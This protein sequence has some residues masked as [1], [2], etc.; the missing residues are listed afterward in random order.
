MKMEGSEYWTKAKELAKKVMLDNSGGHAITNPKNLI[1]AAQAGVVGGTALAGSGLFVQSAA[2]PRKQAQTIEEVL[3]SDES[4]QEAIECLSKNIYHE[5]RGENVDG[6][7]AVALIT[8][9][10]TLEFGYPKTVCGVVY[11]PKQ[12]SWTFDR[13]ILKRPL[14]E[15]SYNKIRLMAIQ[16]LSDR[17][18]DEVVTLL[19]MSLGLP[20]AT[21]FYKKV[22]F[23]GSAAVEAFFE[24]L[25]HAGKRGNHD[26]YVQ[27]R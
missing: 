8:L 1:K 2:A 14:D 22:G 24:T 13:E 27:K 9:A 3:A 5:A 18:V 11:Q 16:L 17:R 20:S 25:E 10:R 4:P 6:Q 23:K 19:S 21:L 12:F 26:F 7:L 15:K